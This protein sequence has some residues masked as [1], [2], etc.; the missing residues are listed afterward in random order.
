MKG[1][2][3]DICKSRAVV[4]KDDG[5]FAEV[6]NRNYQVG[7]TVQ[8][9]RP[10][11]MKYLTAAA[12]FVFLMITSVA[13]YRF[14]NTPYSHLYVDINP[15][16]RLDLNY[17]DRV[18]ACTP[19]NED[20][21]DLQID[22]G[23]TEKTLESILKNCEQKGYLTAENNNIDINIFSEH[24]AVID[25]IQ[26]LA[27]VYDGSPYTITMEK[28]TKA[29]SEQANELGI[30]VQKLNA[31]E[32]Y[33]EVFGGDVVDNAKKLKNSS[34]KEINKTVIEEKTKPQTNPSAPVESEKTE[35][36]PKTDKNTPNPNQSNQDNAQA[37]PK[38]GHKSAVD[39]KSGNGNK[40]DTNAK[41]V[42]PEKTDKPDKS[43][44]P[45]TSFER[46]KQPDNNAA[47]ED[48]RDK[49][50]DNNGQSS[51]THKKR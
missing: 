12:C 48:N 29:K 26:A 3:M 37:K 24:K 5:T 45:D 39:N 35:L 50:K 9:V 33:S 21:K 11:Y 15:C 18:I 46:P 34:A 41:P 42:Q 17:F 8:F 49:E 4:L 14:Y 31:I 7:Q 19:L 51:K 10:R 43:E 20:A 1:I 16:L 32:R 2:V 40:K 23:D 6:A 30:S 38:D 22:Y 27:G 44:K 28:T 25:C 13:G 36:S 47:K